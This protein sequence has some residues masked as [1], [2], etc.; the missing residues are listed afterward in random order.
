LSFRLTA[1]GSSARR[2]AGLLIWDCATGRTVRQVEFTWAD[3]AFRGLAWRADG[4]G[5]VLVQP[6][7]G[8]P[9]LWDFTDEKVKPLV[10]LEGKEERWSDF[11][12]FALSPDG[13]FLAAR[14]YVIGAKEVAPIVL[15]EVA[16][17]KR[18]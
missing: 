17:G 11:N 9:Y 6:R 12:R 3:A 2:E 15:W 7:D 8:E 5:V 14:L 13:K 16:P 18:L 10:A 4:R 1:S